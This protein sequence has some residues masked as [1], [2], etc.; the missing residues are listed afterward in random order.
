MVIVASDIKLFLSGGAFNT[1]PNAS[2]GG[3][4]SNQEIVGIT[5]NLFDDISD[6][7]NDD[8]RIDFRCFYVSNENVTDTWGGIEA[9][10]LS[11]VEGGSSVELGISTITDQQN[12]TITGTASGGSFTISYLGDNVV[13]SHDANLATWASNLQ[14]GLNGLATLSGVAVSASESGSVIT[15]EV[16]FEGNDDNRNHSLIVL[17]INAITGS[18][19]IDIE[20]IQAGAP[21]NSTA[22]DI[23]AFDTTPPTGVD[24][25]SGS[26]SIGDLQATDNFPLWVRRTTVAGVDPVEDDGFSLRT[27]GT[28]S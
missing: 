21:I 6:E 12:I 23:G 16:S 26:L 9:V 17:V 22:P 11:Q 13:V 24:F 7:E 19:T 4:I 15:F 5:N 28:S 14:S 20:K 10:I 18:P 2:L 1:D 25:S 3:E 27:S 8:G